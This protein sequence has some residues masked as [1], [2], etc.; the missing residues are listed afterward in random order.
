MTDPHPTDTDRR[1]STTS[2]KKDRAVAVGAIVVGVLLVIA[3]AINI[4]VTLTRAQP[5]S[6]DEL[7]QFVA[8]IQNVVF[9][10]PETV[11]EVRQDTLGK[12]RP[13]AANFCDRLAAEVRADARTTTTTGTVP[14]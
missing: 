8:C 2:A 4:A 13:A 9:A 11:A 12:P 3:F 7:D 1:T 10:A 6:S 14:P 5:A